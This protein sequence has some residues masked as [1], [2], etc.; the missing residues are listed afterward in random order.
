MVVL[1]SCPK[2][3]MV[4]YLEKTDG[5][6]EI[7]EIIN[8]LT[9]S[10]IHHALILRTDNHLD[11]SPT[12]KF[13]DSILEGS[14]RNHGGQS[15]SDRSPSQ[16]LRERLAA[17]KSLKNHWMQKEHVSK[18]GRKTAKAKHLVHKDP[19]FDKLPDDTVDYMES[20]N[21]QDEGRGQD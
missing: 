12:T 21:A 8:F 14:G 19:A 7:H 6:A 17:K 18:Q 2:H 20:E 11:L 13:P 5:N 10:S 4:A 16:G 3:N 1:E 9:R 15:S